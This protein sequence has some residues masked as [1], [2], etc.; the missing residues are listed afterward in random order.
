MLYHETPFYVISTWCR[1]RLI[2]AVGSGFLSVASSANSLLDH[3][4]SIRESYTFFSIYHI[5]DTFS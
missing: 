1:L 3:G 5:R 2:E 4:L